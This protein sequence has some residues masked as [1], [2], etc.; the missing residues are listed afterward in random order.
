M[1]CLFG[2]FLID[3]LFFH[4][5]LFQYKTGQLKGMFNNA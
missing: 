1:Q 2:I 3:I 5:Y 4:N